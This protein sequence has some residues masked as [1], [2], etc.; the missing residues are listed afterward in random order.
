[1][2]LR[3]RSRNIYSISISFPHFRMRNDRVQYFRNTFFVDQF[4]CIY[5]DVIDLHCKVDSDVQFFLEGRWK[6]GDEQQSMNYYRVKGCM[7]MGGGWDEK[8]ST[9]LVKVG[10]HNI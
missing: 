5:V 10:F 6:D 2:L 1:M 7:V 4:I 8:L 9:A 3:K